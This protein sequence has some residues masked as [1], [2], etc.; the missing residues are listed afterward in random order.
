M[1][2]DDDGTKLPGSRGQDN[3]TVH[4]LPLYL[5]ELPGRL[6]SYISYRFL[7]GSYTF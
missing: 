4:E 5:H 6:R 7:Y 2:K 1:V 3:A